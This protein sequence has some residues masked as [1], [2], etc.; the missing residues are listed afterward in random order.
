M[1]CAPSWICGAR[2]LI[3]WRAIVKYRA[4][5]IQAYGAPDSSMWRARFKYLSFAFAG[6]LST[7]YFFLSSF[8]LFS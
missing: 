3:I 7:I 1:L 4:R 5:Q 2:K 6:H 8:T